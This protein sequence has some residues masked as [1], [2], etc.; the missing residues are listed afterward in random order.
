MELQRPNRSCVRGMVRWK[1]FVLWVVGIAERHA[2][3]HY[4][5]VCV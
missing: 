1:S 5:V 2:Y 4:T 3:V